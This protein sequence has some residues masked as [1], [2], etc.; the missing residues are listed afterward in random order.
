MGAII[1]AMVLAFTLVVVK[2]GLDYSKSK[3][4]EVGEDAPDST[5][6]LS[7]LEEMISSAVSDATEP[8][9]ERID[10]LEQKQLPAGPGAETPLLQA[11]DTADSDAETPVDQ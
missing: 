2:M 1:V 3:L 6:L 7:E 11:G 10:Q 8:L 4:L 9:R 5:L